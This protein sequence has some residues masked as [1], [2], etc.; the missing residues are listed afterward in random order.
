MQSLTVS[1]HWAVDLLQKAAA[2]P[3]GGGQWNS[4]NT[5]PVAWGQWAAELLQYT[6]PSL[7]T[8][9]RETPAIQCLTA[10]G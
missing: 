4:C 10:W 6:A 2:P 5:P 9:G 8:A 7:G 1:G 3:A